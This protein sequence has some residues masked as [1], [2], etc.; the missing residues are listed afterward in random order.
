MKT[1]GVHS[2]KQLWKLTKEL[3]FQPRRSGPPSLCEAAKGLEKARHKS[4][5]T[6]NPLKPTNMTKSYKVMWVMEIDQLE[7]NNQKK[8]SIHI[9]TQQSGTNCTVIAEDWPFPKIWSKV[10]PTATAMCA[11]ELHGFMTCIVLLT[12][13]PFLPTLS[14]LLSE[15]SAMAWKRALVD[16]NG[17]LRHLRHI[18]TTCDTTCEIMW[19]ISAWYYR[20]RLMSLELSRKTFSFRPMATAATSRSWPGSLCDRSVMARCVTV[21][22]SCDHMTSVPFRTSFSMSWQR[23]RKRWR[24]TWQLKTLQT[25]SKLCPNTTYST[26]RYL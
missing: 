24:Q 7:A 17:H 18:D 20:S 23:L 11:F 13:K 21:W 1:L 9:G 19:D 14:L 12:S 2:Q 26:Y 5:D 4:G 15:T 6:W 16:S 25:S 22:L 3:S 8:W 10:V